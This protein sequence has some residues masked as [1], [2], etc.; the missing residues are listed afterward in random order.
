[1]K[2]IGLDIHGA[3]FTYAVISETGKIIQCL[4]RPTSRENL[5]ESVASVTGPKQLTVEECHLAQWVKNVLE[6]YVDKLIVC[7]PT[8]NHWIAKGEFVD[9]AV[10]AVKLARLLRG[11]Y[12]KEIRHPREPASEF[13][14]LFLHYYDLNQQL[15][16]FK[17][18]LKAV[19][20]QAAVSTKVKGFYTEPVQRRLQNALK[21]AVYLRH[22][23]IQLCAMTGL[24]EDLKQQTFDKMVKHAKRNGNFKRLDGIPGAGP[25]ISAGYLALVE[26]PY[27]FSRRNKLWSYAGFA[28]ARQE[29]DGVVYRHRASRG[30]NRALKWVVI[31]HFNAAVVLSKKPNRFK[32]QYEALIARGLDK[33]SSRRQVCRSILSVV[34]ALWMKEEDYRETR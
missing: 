6:P 10:S 1:M 28:N 16:T 22:E 19:Y 24:V 34:R 27:R 17:N 26:T 29:S 20:R 12:L 14:R 8:Q 3:T 23:A 31:E 5:V 33:T 18:K 21:D 4:S 30:G 2:S 9:D 11:G 25:V 13:R 7:D 32:K 15:V